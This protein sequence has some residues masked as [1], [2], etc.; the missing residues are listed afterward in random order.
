VVP[1]PG[2]EPGTPGSKGPKTG[3]TFADLSP[4][5]SRLPK[6]DRAAL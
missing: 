1:R 5:P 2:L 4:K 6:A 3:F